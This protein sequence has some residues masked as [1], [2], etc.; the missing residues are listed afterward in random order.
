MW[1]ELHQIWTFTSGH[2][3]DPLV[4]GVAAPRHQSVGQVSVH[5]AVPAVVLLVLILD[6]RRH[7]LGGGGRQS[8]AF[9]ARP[10]PLRN[11]RQTY[12]RTVGPLPGPEVLGVSLVQTHPEPATL[13]SKTKTKQD[14]KD[15]KTLT[16]S[17]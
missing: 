8:P 3:T 13:C 16:V 5:G 6:E 4:F 10:R 7:H 15:L 2:F 12:R 1:A 14:Q 17:V 9:C 11:M